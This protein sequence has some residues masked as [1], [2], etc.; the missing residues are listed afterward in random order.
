MGHKADT[1]F[2]STTCIVKNGE[3]CLCWHASLDGTPAKC[4]AL[5]SRAKGG[6]T[7]VPPMLYNIHEHHYRFS[8]AW[9]KLTKERDMRVPLPIIHPENWLPGVESGRLFAQCAHSEP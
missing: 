9:S 4:C 8:D 3:V 6:Q 2:I 7:S 1:A 5:L